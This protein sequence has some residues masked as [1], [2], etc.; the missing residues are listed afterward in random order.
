MAFH[1]HATSADPLRGLRS[2]SFRA[3]SARSTTAE[4]TSGLAE[5]AVPN[6]LHDR[7]G[8][9]VEFHYRHIV[10]N[11]QSQLLKCIHCEHEVVSIHDH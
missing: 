11:P 10:G 4:I 2:R 5:P 7:R 9:V 6:V 1:I 8:N 3:R